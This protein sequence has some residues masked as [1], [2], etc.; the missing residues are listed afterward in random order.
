[1]AAR[2]ASCC[3]N[4]TKFSCVQHLVFLRIINSKLSVAVKLSQQVATILNF[5]E[6]IHF[7]HPASIR[8]IKRAQIDVGVGTTKSW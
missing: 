2:P 8:A 1:M 4:L 5:K 6:F 7:L 3:I